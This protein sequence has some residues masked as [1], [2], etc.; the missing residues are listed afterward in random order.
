MTSAPTVI[1]LITACC[2][3]R[4]V[5]VDRSANRALT[6]MWNGP[7]SKVSLRNSL[8]DGAVI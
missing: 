2:L 6:H 5:D 8:L 4:A 3:L 1:L 7:V